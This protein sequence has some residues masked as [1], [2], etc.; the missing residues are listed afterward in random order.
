MF[1]VLISGPVKNFVFPELGVKRCQQYNGSIR[2][3][4]VE[5][6][7]SPTKVD[8][9]FRPVDSQPKENQFYVVAECVLVR[10]FFVG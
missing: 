7:R 5:V 4:T 1:L 3:S 9:G 10:S 2:V 6:G 8:G